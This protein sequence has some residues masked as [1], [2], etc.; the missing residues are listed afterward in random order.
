MNKMLHKCELP[1]Q[2]FIG[3]EADFYLK[4]GVLLALKARASM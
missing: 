4:L 1:V 2:Y 3:L